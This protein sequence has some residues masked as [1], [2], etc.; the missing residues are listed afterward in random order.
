MVS[1]LYLLMTTVVALSQLR[2]RKVKL[3]VTVGTEA[4]LCACRQPVHRSVPSMQSD[5]CKWCGQSVQVSFLHPFRNPGNTYKMI[6]STPYLRMD[7]HT[8]THTHTHTRTCTQT[9]THTHTHTRI[10]KYIRTCTRA[11]L[12]T[13]ARPRAHPHTLCC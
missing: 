7:T 8:H 1:F 5:T 12:H 11:R 4:I 2:F 10:C 3:P 9:H 13:H 6:S